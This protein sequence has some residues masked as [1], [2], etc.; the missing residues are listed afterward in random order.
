MERIDLESPE[1]CKKFKKVVDKK[2]NLC[3]SYKAV[4]KQTKATKNKFKKV[5]DKSEKL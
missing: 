5:V 4:A 2:H 1:E 3:Y